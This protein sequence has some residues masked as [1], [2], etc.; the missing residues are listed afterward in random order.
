MD[1]LIKRTSPLCTAAEETSSSG[2]LVVSLLY[3]RPKRSSLWCPLD[4]ARLLCSS[5]LFPRSFFFRKGVYFTTCLPILGPASSSG[6]R[7]LAFHLAQHVKYIDDEPPYFPFLFLSGFL[8]P[9]LMKLFSVS[10]LSSSDAKMAL[11]CCYLTSPRT[12]STNK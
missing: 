8:G 3:K 2:D 1:I 11:R 7:G 12:S 9:S 10:S 6:S 5:S 4:F